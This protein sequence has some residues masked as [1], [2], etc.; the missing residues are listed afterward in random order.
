MEPTNSRV[1]PG[2]AD[3]RL[4]EDRDHPGALA[5]ADRCEVGTKPLQLGV[6]VDEGSIVAPRQ[7]RGVGVD[8][9]EPERPDLVALALDLQRLE[10]CCLD[11]MRDEGVA[12][13][14]PA[15]FARGRALLEPL[16]QRDRLA[17]DEAVARSGVAGDDLAAVDPDPDLEARAGELGLERRDR[18][19]QFDRCADRAQG[20]VLAYGRD[21]EDGHHLVADELLDRAPVPL[22]RGCGQ[23]EEA[24]HHIPERLG[25]DPP[26]ELGERD[27]VAEE[28][29]DRLARLE[30]GVGRERSAACVAEARPVRVDSAAGG[31]DGGGRCRS[32]RV[33][34]E[35]VSVG[36][37]AQRGR[38]Y[39]KE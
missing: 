38:A 34:A 19:A 17:G 37:P 31:T 24:R 7:R 27:D 39:R 11:R 14:R 8:G 36:E 6:A 3:A 9:F 5:A 26:G 28:H 22:D 23:V 20:V 2:L 21:A 1:E 18:V 4:T 12:S 16:A 10:R 33:L 25:V 30:R 32:R 15:R 35:P 13:F 29:G